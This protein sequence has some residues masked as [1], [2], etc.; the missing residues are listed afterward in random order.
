LQ[1]QEAAAA[2]AVELGVKRGVPTLVAP[3]AETKGGLYY[4]SNLDQNIAV[5]VQTVYCFAATH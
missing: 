4:L 1:G 3:A 5:I 2:A